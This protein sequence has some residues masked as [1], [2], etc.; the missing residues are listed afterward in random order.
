MFWAL[1][2][3]LFLSMLLAVGVRFFLEVDVVLFFRARDSKTSGL[4]LY[5]QH[6]RAGGGFVGAAGRAPPNKPILVIKSGRSPAAQRLL[7]SHS[8][9]D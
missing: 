2:V 4:V 9:M 1:Q 8:G 5:L 3:Y 6:L 7:H